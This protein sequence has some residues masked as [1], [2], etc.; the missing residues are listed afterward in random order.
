MMKQIQS[1]D[2]L[3]PYGDI[4]DRSIVAHCC[5]CGYREK[6]HLYLDRRGIPRC[7]HC[8]TQVRTQPMECRRQ[9]DTRK[10]VER[11]QKP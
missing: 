8:N 11:K 1:I 5:R 4:M 9:Y 10:R 7:Q 6:K 3:P 2:E